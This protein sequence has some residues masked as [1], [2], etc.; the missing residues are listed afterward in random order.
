MDYS[1]HADP[2]ACL[3]PRF[4]VGEAWY[5]AL[6]A[7]YGVLTERQVVALCASKMARRHPSPG[8][9]RGE[10]GASRE[11]SRWA[12]RGW[13]RLHLGSGRQKLHQCE[14][15]ARF[16]ARRRAEVRCDIA[17]CGCSSCLSL[18]EAGDVAQGS[19]GEVFHRCDSGL[20]AGLGS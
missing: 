14:S 10:G 2:A 1:Y 4:R 3:R 11:G 16:S 12:G 13:I 6:C 8:A 7:E 5:R 15:R 9:G 17:Y 19:H 20:F 18:L